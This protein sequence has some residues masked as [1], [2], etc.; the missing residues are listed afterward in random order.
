MP[1][2]KRSK[3]ISLTK[4]KSKGSNM[5]QKQVEEV[6]D[7]LDEYSQIYVLSCKNIRTAQMNEVRKEF[8]D[9]KIYMGK[10]SVAAVAL[11]RNQEDEFKDNLRHVSG[12]LTGNVC[13]MFTNRDKKSTMKYFKKLKSPEYASAGDIVKEDVILEEGDLPFAGSML[14]Q[15]RTLGLVVELEEGVVNLKNRFVCATKG[16]ALNPEQAKMLTHLGK[17]LGFFTLTPVCYWADGSF[18]EL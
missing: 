9:S 10:N 3:V 13:L 1:K 5:R 2:S 12:F 4:T 16:K 6:R 15:L 14:D 8:E 18:E 7:A 11:G 17:K